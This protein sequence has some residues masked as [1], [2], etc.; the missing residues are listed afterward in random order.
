MYLLN[1]HPDVKPADMRPVTGQSS[2]DALV[3]RD[4]AK[5][6]FTLRSPIVCIGTGLH[7]GK[8][9]RLELRPAAVDHGIVFYRTDEGDGTPIPARYDHVV[10]T[11]LSTVIASPQA[12]LSRVA[13]IEHLMSALHANRIDNAMVLVDGPEIPVLDGSAVEFDRLIQCAGRSSL[14]AP[15]RVIEVLKPVEYVDETGAFARLSP[16][17]SRGAPKELSLSM[18]IDFKARAIGQQ[19]LDILLTA[20]NFRTELA[21]GRTFVE[22]HEIEALRASGL[23]Q[24][25]SLQNA[26]VVDGA[27]VINPGGLRHADEFVRH[28]MLDAVGDL[29]LAGGTLCAHFE[30]YKSGH[31]INNQLLRRLFSSHENWGVL[32]YDRRETSEL[33]TVA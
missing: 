5:R 4:L 31:R 1:A 25:G 32:K 24:G 3:H 9:I 14:R 20:Q 29:Y 17:R 8:N 15:R 12:P 26:I 19:R 18:S 28:K 23:V 21:D 10:D 13:T 30:G 11:R 33:H 6:Q 22:K 27:Q 7:T 2:N 16:T